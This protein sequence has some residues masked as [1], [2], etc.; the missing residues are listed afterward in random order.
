MI[1]M[2]ISYF[3]IGLW[4][5]LGSHFRVRPANSFDKMVIT[6]Y[7]EYFNIYCGFSKASLIFK[8]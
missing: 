4:G 6:M 5:C 8:F 2:I 1:T 7:I 3:F